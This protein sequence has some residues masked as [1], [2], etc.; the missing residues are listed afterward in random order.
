MW[1][2][3]GSPSQGFAASNGIPEALGWA[4][5]L[6]AAGF[7]EVFAQIEMEATVS[8]SPQMVS[9]LP[10]DTV[11]PDREMLSALWHLNNETYSGRQYTSVTTPEGQQAFVDAVADPSL[12]EVVLDQESHVPV[13]FVGASIDSSGTGWIEELSVHPDARRQGLGGAL[14]R[15]ALTNLSGRGVSSVR[16]VTDRDNVS[17]ARTLY[18]QFGFREAVVHSRYRLRL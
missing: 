12:W 17:G 9:T 1:V 3:E 2:A 7:V 16:L 4:T 5:E 14:L 11:S 13:A 10:L 18:E 6:E 15:N 8:P